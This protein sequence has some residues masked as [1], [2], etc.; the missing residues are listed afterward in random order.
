MWQWDSVLWVIFTLIFAAMAGAEA[1][2]WRAGI[3]VDLIDLGFSDMNAAQ[4]KLRDGIVDTDKRTHLSAAV[5]YGLA[6]AVA[7]FSLALSLMD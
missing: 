1:R 4:E 2:M 7:L 6:F 5:S 3:R